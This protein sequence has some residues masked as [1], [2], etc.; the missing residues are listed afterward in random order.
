MR[1]PHPPPRTTPIRTAATALLL[2]G[3]A[4]CTD[5]LRSLGPNPVAAEAH[6][7]QL[8]EALATRFSPTEFTSK[9]DVARVKL[10]QGALAPSRIF[11]DSAVWE[12]R[13]SAS[14]RELFISGSP[15]PDG[16]YRLETRP[17]LTP[18]TRPGD[19]RHSVSLELLRE[20]NYRWDTKVDLAIGAVTAE[21]MSVLISALLRAPEGKTERELRDEYRAAF[22]R[23]MAAW[24][25]GFSIDSLR[26][27]PGALGTTSVVMTAGFHSELMKPTYPALAG[28]L[29]KYLGPAKYHFVLAD[30]AGAALF[31]A[32]GHDRMLTLRYRLQQGKLTTLV[33]PPRAWPD[34]L[35]LTSDVSLKVKV[36]RVGFHAL[37]TDFVI[38]NTGRER[39]WTILAQHEPKWDL[40]FITEQLIRSPLRR[41]FEPDGSLIK[42]SVR[43]TVGGQTVFSRRTR[44]DVQESMIMR[45][46]GGLASH[47]V[48][49]LDKQ[50]EAEED[51]FFRDAFV[52]LQGDLRALTPR[53]K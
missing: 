9:Y 49:D 27:A 11:N 2:I 10:A 35:Q 15:L 26:I 8:F 51:R 41:P 48:G 39:S 18:T 40:P 7:E 32:V 4:A 19:S 44:L 34:S 31:D 1:T 33:G 16:K 3:S 21:E 5:S 50:V 24:G 23:A 13:P 43:D 37:V 22:P 38:A 47:A 53:W 52:A 20:S 28:Y 14:E 42:L 46:L 17:S 30:R 6:A 36:F 25:H 29:D 12:A 45:F